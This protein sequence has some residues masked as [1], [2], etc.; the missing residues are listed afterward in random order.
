M[1]IGNERNLA[2]IKV[3]LEANCRRKNFV[4]LKFTR[5]HATSYIFDINKKIKSVSSK[6]E[7]VRDSFHFNNKTWTNKLKKKY[8]SN[9]RKQSS[10]SS[11]KNEAS[12]ALL[13]R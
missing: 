5:N 1:K 11:T 2:S 3:F 7:K 9:R 8:I 6:Y 10:V 4:K 12:N 13:Y